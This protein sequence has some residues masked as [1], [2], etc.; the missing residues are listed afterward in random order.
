MDFYTRSVRETLAELGADGVRGLSKKEAGKRLQQYGANRLG[1]KRGKPFLFKFLEQFSDFMVLILL[2]AAGLSFLVSLW[3]GQADFVDPIIILAI[4]FLN[5]IMGLVQEARA[6]RAI[7]SLQALSAPKTRV[8]RG[9]AEMTVDSDTVV[10]GDLL[11]FETGDAVTADVRLVESVGLRVEESSL[12]GES[13]AVA[14][15]HGVQHPKGAPLGERRN[16]VFSGSTIVAG[17]CR[18]IAV[19]TGMATEVGQIARLLDHA[20]TP[21]TPLQRRLGDTGKTMGIFALLICSFI[22]L[23]G[24]IQR[25]DL[26]DSFM[27]AVSLAVAAV[28][29]GLPAIVTI[30]LALGVQRLARRSAI[31]RKLP[32]VETLGSA[33][34]ICS[35]KTGTLT[36]NRMTVQQI[37]PVTGEQDSGMRQK[38][39]LYGSLCTNTRI[40]D[41]EV[42]GDP[43]ERAIVEA[44]IR[45]GLDLGQAKVRHPRMGEVP[46]DSA[47]K[48]MSTLHQGGLLLVKGAPDV[49]LGLCEQVA[50]STGGAVRLTD[51]ARREILAQNGQMAN[52]ALRVIAV[53]YREMGEA[54]VGANCVRPHVPIICAPPS[55]A[56]EPVA[57]GEHSS[58]LHGRVGKEGADAQNAPLRANANTRDV[59]GMILPLRESAERG[60]T[61]LGLIAMQDPPRPEARE[62][63][64]TCRRAGIRPVMITG[65]HAATAAAIAQELGILTGNRGVLT[66]AELDA[67]SDEDLQ[68]MV[69]SV[70]VFARVSPLHKS[71]VVEALQTNGEIV[72]M[73]GDGV[74]DAPALKI[75]DIGCAMGKSGTDVARDASDMI[76]TDD[77][78]ATIVSAVREG[79]GIYQNMVKSVHFLLSCNVGEI[80]TILIAV[81]IGM[82]PPLLP[83]QLLWVNLVT[84]SFPALALGAEKAERDIM[85]RPPVSPKSSMF[86]GGLGIDIIFQGMMIG[87]LSLW[88]FF[89]GVQSGD[90]TTGRTF[91]FAVLSLS[92]LVHACNVRSRES[93]FKIGLFSNGK[94]VLALLFCGAMQVAVIGHP[95]L[96][97]VFG[98]APLTLEQWR[99]VLL[100]VP[101]PLVV[102]ELTKL[103]RRGEKPVH[104]HS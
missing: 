64:L 24:V 23:L 89:L 65:D 57:A 19:S 41:K 81:L 9:G 49:L 28:P 35:D 21:Q 4:V 100:L 18:G 103:L 39:L 99:T 11:R 25:T 6:E 14:K 87:G 51:G 27:L 2:G 86:S 31:V 36:Q 38:L 93:L 1:G 15:D 85:D 84:D 20:E 37:V 17:R 61:F 92:Q 82:P 69:K 54:L 45:E 60:L 12:T 75:S 46:F 53:A 90:Y 95:T 5:A 76:L 73:T 29:E 7:Q 58:P 3:E 94:M 43:T 55:S 63:V 104:T 48:R 83:I 47:R 16:M 78:F 34:V 74:N 71:R 102:V 96:A 67:L 66:G 62:A 56:V 8:M 42:V 26:L 98:V 10:P 88:A 32:A 33:T 30:V 101:I 80:L 70:A 77:N 72:A 40:S 52:R 13:T 44:A 79:R 68:K 59:G 97:G 91:A 50:S 22:F